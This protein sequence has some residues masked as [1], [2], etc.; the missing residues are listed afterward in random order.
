ME[1][2]RR[3]RWCQ[4]IYLLRMN[5]GQAINETFTGDSCVYLTGK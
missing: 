1:E 5:F 3:K 2:Y 4:V